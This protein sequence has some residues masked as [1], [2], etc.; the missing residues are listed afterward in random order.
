MKITKNFLKQIIL[1]ELTAIKGGGEG[2]GEPA[3]A[4]K[5]SSIAGEGGDEKKQKENLEQFKNR[6]EH[7]K[8]EQSKTADFMQKFKPQLLL[9]MRMIN[10]GKDVDKKYDMTEAFR[11][12]ENVRHPMWTLLEDFFNPE[13]VY[14]PKQNWYLT[15]D[16][17]KLISPLLESSFPVPYM[18]YKKDYGKEDLPFERQK[19][20]LTQYV[21]EKCGY[22]KEERSAYYDLN[23]WY[24]TKK[25]KA[26]KMSTKDWKA[27]MR[28]AG[29]EEFV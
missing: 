27:M 13:N 20:I 26:K 17:K 8:N 19:N 1:E 14:S 15:P 29:D 25:E 9:Y 18:K 2:T 24:Y 11:H 28:A 3:A 21:L 23:H 22:N 10:A 7:I 12:V 16:Q 4:G 6:I 5:L